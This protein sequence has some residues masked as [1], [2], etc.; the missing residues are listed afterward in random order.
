MSFRSAVLQAL[1]IIPWRAEAACCRGRVSW[2]GPANGEYNARMTSSNASRQC[3]SR[4]TRRDFLNATARGG[5][6]LA[7]APAVL[8]LTGCGGQ[9][10]RRPNILFAISD[11]QSFPHAGA[12]GDPVVKTPAFD[13]V[14]E[15]GI[16]FTNAICGSPGC[17]P[18]RAAILTGR[19]HWQLEEAG[20]HASYFPT[21]FEVYPDMLEAAGYHTGHTGKGGGPA[22]FEASGWEH[23]PAGSPYQTREFDQVPPGIR[24]TDYASNFADFLKEKPAEAPFCFWYGGS[25][26]HRSFKLGAGVESGKK[27]EDVIVPSFLPDCEVV[28][29][30]I[31]DYYVEIEHFDTQLSK[32]LDMLEAAGEIDNTLIVATSDNG[33]AFPRAKATMY[34]YGIHLPLAVCWPASFGGGRTVDDMI[35]F[36]DFAPTFLEAAGLPA[37]EVMTGKSFVDVLASEASGTVDASRT[38][39]FSGRER[40]SHSRFDNL[41]YPSRALRTKQYLYIRNFAPDR[42]PAGAPDLFADIDGCPSKDYLIENREK[43]GVRQLYELTCEKNPAEQLYDIRQDPSCL[44]NLA[45]S[46]E[47]AELNGQ[48]RK[49][50]EETLTAQ[51]DPRMLG[52]GDIFE[53]YPR[54]NRM[55]PQLG[56]FAEAGQYNPKYQKK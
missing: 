27:L 53:S 36:T 7:G 24:K 44:N 29:S 52:G 9:P 40:H 13:R 28:R 50:L 17:A 20:T 39:A 8:S 6:A 1:D 18:S 37:P 55:R 25:E 34:E 47:H 23:N 51:N 45:E 15:R 30:D 38:S 46:A 19:S 56:G 12:A 11:D 22:N 33:M 26:P 42:Y 2:A 3:G 48:L 31:L 49:Q 21:K 5:L 32:M 10:R 43:E 54:F 4:P 16:L 35:S 41:G 14:A